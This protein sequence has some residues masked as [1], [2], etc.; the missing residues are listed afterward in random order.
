MFLR[1]YKS[2]P[3]STSPSVN[4]SK[5]NVT[6]TARK[7]NVLFVCGTLPSSSSWGHVA[8]VSSSMTRTKKSN[9]GVLTD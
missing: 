5:E 9:Y 8:S 4:K 7:H 3:F 2:M 1:N 6:Q